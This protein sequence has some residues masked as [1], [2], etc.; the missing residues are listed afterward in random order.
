[1]SLFGT[2]VKAIKITVAVI[3]LLL[4]SHTV[5][6][7]D[8]EPYPI[9]W[10]PSLEL[11]SLDQID[12]RLEKPFWPGDEGLVMGKWDA[13]RYSAKDHAPNCATMIDLD[14]K[15]YSP[16][17]SSNDV[18]IQMIFLAECGTIARL[19]DARPARQS[20]LRDFVLD[21]LAPHYLPGLMSTGGE[22]VGRCLLLD[23]N[24]RRTP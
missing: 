10:S 7:S 18:A 17:G 12:K 19:K 1:M 21:D 4:L 20:F 11:E 5:S 8:E 6:A 13:D 2:T 3:A 23:A 22:C 16:T 15:G 9:W 24:E 14:A